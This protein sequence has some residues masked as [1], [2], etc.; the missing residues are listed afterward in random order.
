MTMQRNTLTSIR[1]CAAGGLLAVTL[2]AIAACG[3][4]AAPVAA[5]GP[6]TS[7][8]PTNSAGSP[9]QTTPA[10]PANTPAATASTPA[11]A[12]VLTPTP[13]LEPPITIQVDGRTILAPPGFSFPEDSKVQ[14]TFPGTVILSAPR[15]SAV[16]SYFRA[17]LPKAGYVIGSDT[18]GTLTFAGRGWVGM[19][20]ANDSGGT[21]NFS[22]A[23]PKATAA[24]TKAEPGPMTGLDLGVNN[25]PFNFRFPPG[26]KLTELNDPASGASFTITSPPPA[27][28]LAFYRQYLPIGHFTVTSDSTDNGVTTIEFTDGDTESGKL[29]FSATHVRVTTSLK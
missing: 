10:T 5:S 19:V 12:P 9:G 11:P 14:T 17:A 25:V 13:S 3:N 18:G 23:R 26:T 4:A 27:D 1:R 15:G 24:D 2:V 6:T 20:V 29:V 16:S 21:I 22:Q 8:G 7:A 28:A